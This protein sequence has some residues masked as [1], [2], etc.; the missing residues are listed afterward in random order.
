MTN[1]PPI[2][3]TLFGGPKSRANYQLTTL[4][5][6]KAEHIN[7]SGAKGNVIMALESIGPCTISELANQIQMSPKYVKQI[8]DILV[9]DGWARKVSSEEGAG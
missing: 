6:T 9:R 1:M 5:K 3:I 7:I 4:G 2:K 8:M